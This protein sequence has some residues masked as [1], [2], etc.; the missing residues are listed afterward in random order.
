MDWL[1]LEIVQPAGPIAGAATSMAQDPLG[2]KANG[3]IEELL[4]ELVLHEFNTPHRW[5]R[6]M[7]TTH[8]YDT[9]GKTSY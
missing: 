9:E 5:S 2:V 6:F 8:S 3:N 7:L 4:P 1:M